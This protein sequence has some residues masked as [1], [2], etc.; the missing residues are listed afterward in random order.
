MRLRD[1]LTVERMEAGLGLKQLT[2]RAHATVFLNLTIILSAVR[3]LKIRLGPDTHD[4][5]PT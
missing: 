3:A 1:S 2:S 5:A 4:A